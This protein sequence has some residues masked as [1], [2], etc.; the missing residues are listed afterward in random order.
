MYKVFNETL[1]TDMGRTKVGK[2]LKTTDAQAVWKEYSEYMRTS[3][4]GASEKRKITH[5]LT[6]TVLDTQFR[7]TTQQFVLHFNEQ[8]RRLDDLTDITE[9][10]PESIKMALHQNAVKDIPQL[11]IVETLDDYTQQPVGMD[12][13]HTSTIHLT[14][15]SSSMLVSDMIPPIHLL[16]LR[17]GMSMLLL[18]LRT[19]T[20]LKNPTKHISLRI[21]TPHQMTSI[22]YIRPNIAETPTPLSGFQKD[23]SSKPTSAAP[24]KPSAPKKYDGPVYVPAEVYKLLTPEAVLALKKYNSVALNKMAKNRGIHV[25]DVTD[26][27]LSIAETNITEEQADSHQDEDAH[28]G[29]SDPILDYINSQHHQEDDMNRDLQAII[30]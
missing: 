20:P 26:Q 6:N 10:M 4:K 7:R 3:S 12:H 27:G 18:V 23:H 21:L 16:P 13:S 15:I 2:Y 22:R 1:L 29:D 30:S 14:T 25:T 8:F 5:Y 17:E 28:E 19:S 9:R 11:S 24:K